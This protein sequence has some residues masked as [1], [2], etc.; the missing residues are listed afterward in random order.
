M[1][2]KIE[3]GLQF[4]AS[5][6][7]PDLNIGVTELTLKMEGNTFLSMNS[8]KSRKHDEDFTL[9]KKIPDR[10]SGPT[11]LTFF[12]ASKPA[13]TSSMLNVQVLDRSWSKKGEER[14]LNKGGT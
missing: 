5:A 14:S 13:S 1:Y 2:F 9:F 3:T 11:D 6:L 8:L 4:L 12:R 10:P 7:S